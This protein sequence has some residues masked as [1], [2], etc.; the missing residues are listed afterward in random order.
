VTLIE[1]ARGHIVGFQAQ[2]LD[3]IAAFLLLDVFGYATAISESRFCRVAA[4]HDAHTR[5][6]A[7][8]TMRFQAWW[9]RT[10][11]A[12]PVRFCGNS[13]TGTA[14]AVTARTPVHPPPPAGTA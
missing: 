2:M 1:R 5:A 3:G 6:K 9:P 12:T 10:A 14:L 11:A 8:N 13:S 7:P 4:E